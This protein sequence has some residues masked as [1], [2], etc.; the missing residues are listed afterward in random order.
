MWG[1]EAIL[2]RLDSTG[3][4]LHSPPR[5]RSRRIGAMPGHYGSW[6]TRMRIKSD[7]DF[8]AGLMFIAFGL[9]F[10][11]F[12]MGTPEFID[13]L[14]GPSSSTATRWAARCGWGPPIFRSCLA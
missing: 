4:M 5:S 3:P 9:F 11:V 8:W 6:R 13:N 1:A 10:I 2:R 7:Q 14:V 12:A